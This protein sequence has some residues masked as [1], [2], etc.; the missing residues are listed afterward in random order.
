MLVVL[1]VL[2]DVVLVVLVKKCCFSRSEKT[3]P[4]GTCFFH[5]WKKQVPRGLVFSSSKKLD[6]TFFYVRSDSAQVISAVA[7]PLMHYS[8]SAA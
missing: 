4:L 1:V 2:V 6:F 8:S 3:S 7:D 5:F